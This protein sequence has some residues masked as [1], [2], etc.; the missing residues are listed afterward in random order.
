MNGYTQYVCYW[1]IL[2]CMNWK[3]MHLSPLLGCFNLVFA[4]EAQDIFII[5]LITRS[6][7][8]SCAVS[9]ACFVD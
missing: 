7:L 3:A 2:N 1:L 5:S 8:T 9:K 4:A 6:S